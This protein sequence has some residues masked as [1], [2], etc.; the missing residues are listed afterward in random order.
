MPLLIPL[1]ILATVTLGRAYEW[2]KQRRWTALVVLGL[3]T[4]AVAWVLQGP[5]LPSNL[6]VSFFPDYYNQGNK[7]WNI[8]E[9]E[10]ATAEYE[11]ALSVR[12]GDHPGVESLYRFLASVYLK[13]GQLSRAQALLQ[14]AA[15]RYPRNPEFQEKLQM[16]RTLKQQPKAKSEAITPQNP[17]Q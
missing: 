7:Y 6:E 8:G 17:A 13:S 14:K 10:L 11:K 2:A 15:L 9:Y 16:L 12:P 3:A 5:V 4:G 1:S